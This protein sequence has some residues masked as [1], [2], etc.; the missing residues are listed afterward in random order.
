MNQELVKN[1]PPSF[2]VFLLVKICFD[3]ICSCHELDIKLVVQMLLIKQIQQVLI[4]SENSLVLL[5]IS[6]LLLGRPNY[7][8]SVSGSELENL[9]QA[10][11]KL[12]V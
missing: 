7:S 5:D 3:F 8:I 11:A 10:S 9:V 6:H 1:L 2:R 12:S 4:I